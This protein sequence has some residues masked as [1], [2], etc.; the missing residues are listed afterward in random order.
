MKKKQFKKGMT[1]I[2]VILAMAI[3]GII[4]SGFLTMFTSS[5]IWIF[6]AGDRGEAYSF[7]QKDVE[8]RISSE[9][10]YESDTLI[11]TF[12]GEDY[13]IDGGIVEST[14]VINQKDSTLET[15]V[16]LLPTISLDPSVRYEGD[17]ENTVTIKGERT[18][19]SNTNTTIEVY[20]HTGANKLYD[21]SP[22]SVDEA[23]QLLEFSLEDGGNPVH[24]AKGEYIIRVKTTISGKPD[25]LS[26]AK[27]V[28]QQ[29]K[30]I[31]VGDSVVYISANGIEW[32][33]RD[34]YPNIPSTIGLLNSVASNGAKYIAVGGSGKI[35]KS[36][37]NAEW[38]YESKTS[39]EL[40]SVIF[41]VGLNKY[42]ITSIAGKLY[43]LDESDNWSSFS[44]NTLPLYDIVNVSFLNGSD[45]LFALGDG[46][47]LSSND[48]TT[49]ISNSGTENYILGSGADASTLGFSLFSGKMKDNP[50]S[51]VIVKFIHSDS[52]FEYYEG[53][54]TMNDI[55]YSN[56][57]S[58][59]IGVAD[60]GSI[61]TSMDGLNWLLLDTGLTITDNLKSVYTSGLDILISGDSG[62]ILYS[63][64]AGTTWTQ[65]VYYDANWQQV[66]PSIELNSITGK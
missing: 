64:D 65:G 38:T 9:D 3:F 1:L 34:N 52:S 56:V 33:D 60:G 30:Y 55:A 10:S 8:N 14:Q 53:L 22:D 20:D 39:E 21:F 61:Y 37:D 7:A 59:F 36:V 12:E 51:G 2:E 54:T 28:V 17:K 25:E 49:W 45:M 13:S 41:S 31:A 29:S 62:T 5:L 43:S 18:H 35:L 40:T 16:P 44:T 26:R 6:G 27:Y 66:F 19:F 63:S 23:N 15:F 57:S 42:Y 24:L 47:L 11:L 48:G 32:V 46:V 50:S 4:A 58:L